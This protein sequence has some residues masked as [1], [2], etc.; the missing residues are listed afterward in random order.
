VEKIKFNFNR[1]KILDLFKT[2]QH[3]VLYDWKTFQLGK[4]LGNKRVLK[5][6]YG[7][8]L[9]AVSYIM[10]IIILVKKYD[11][12]YGT[13][14]DKTYAHY[15]SY[16]MRKEAFRMFDENCTNTRYKGLPPTVSLSEGI[17]LSGKTLDCRP[18]DCEFDP[19]HSN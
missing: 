12:M 17:W 18:R 9:V 4:G 10:K 2:I 3:W 6:C 14:F 19:P 16:L 7:S 8:S 1:V 5:Y 15:T 11:F 13:V